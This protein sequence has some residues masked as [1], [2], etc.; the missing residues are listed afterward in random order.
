[1]VPDWARLPSDSST[2]STRWGIE[3]G[4]LARVLPTGSPE[5][6]NELVVVLKEIPPERGNSGPR[7]QVA[8]RMGVVLMPYYSLSVERYPEKKV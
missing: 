6:H 4:C 8:G 7:Y 2:S 5:W 3:I 1:M